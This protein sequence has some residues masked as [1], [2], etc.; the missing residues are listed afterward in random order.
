MEINEAL[1]VYK[2]SNIWAVIGVTQ[3][4]TKFGYKI[5]KRLKE[6][7]KEVYGVSPKYSDVDGEKLYLNISDIPKIP[8]VAVFVVNPSIG[9]KELEK[10]NK[11]GI[12]NIWLQ[13]GTISQELIE[14]AD[15]LELNQIDKCVLVVS[16][17]EE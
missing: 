5:F 15:E 2:N 4:K 16:E 1:K 6:V 13:P 10:I 14:K 7:G 17:M 11:M 8:E 3:D 9:I 12:K